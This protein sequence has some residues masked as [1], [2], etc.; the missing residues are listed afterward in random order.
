MIDTGLHATERS[1]VP[2]SAGASSDGQTMRAMPIAVA[3]LRR[4]AITFAAAHGASEQ[5]LK[6][7]ALAISEAVANVVKYAYD[8]DEPGPVHFAAGA[9][10]GVLE[11]VI[12]DSGLG[13]RPGSSDGL[14]LGLSLIAQRTAE[15]R[16]EQRPRSTEVRMR[17]H[18]AR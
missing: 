16:I 10:D 6:D 17:F 12:S 3:A 14:G 4:R 18:L 15:F 2:S 1:P 5:L 8:P 13:F 7:V 9:A 11:I